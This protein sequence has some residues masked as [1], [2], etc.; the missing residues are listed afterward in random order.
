MKNYIGQST[1]AGHSMTEWKQTLPV[2]PGLWEDF[3]L[4]PVAQLADLLGI[5]SLF[6]RDA[7]TL[8]PLVYAFQSLESSLNEQTH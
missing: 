5:I 1:D 3:P 8:Q 2:P 4:I 7:G 6:V